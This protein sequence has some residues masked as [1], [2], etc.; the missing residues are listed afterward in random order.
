MLGSPISGISTV[1]ALHYL[2]NN[3]LLV[4]IRRFRSLI[5]VHLT[6]YVNQSTSPQTNSRLAIKIKKNLH[7]SLDLVKDNA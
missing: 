6:H 7:L 5:T 2:K 1:Q 3:S 4:F